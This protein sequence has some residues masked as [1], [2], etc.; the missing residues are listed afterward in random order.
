MSIR[1]AVS[2]DLDALTW[3]SVAATP[4]D[5]VCPYRYPLR[6]MYPE[7]FEK[8]SKM[9]LSEYLANAQTG[10]SDFMVYEAPSIQDAYGRKVVAYAI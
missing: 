5:P 2:S 1:R 6:E 9:R 7:D 3:I 8:F 10:A 4:A